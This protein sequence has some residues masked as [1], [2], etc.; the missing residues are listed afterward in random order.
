MYLH[1]YHGRKDPAA[2][3]DDWGEGG[4][5]LEGVVH[6]QWTYGCLYVLF[7]TSEDCEAARRKT[8]WED[9]PHENSLTMN[10]DGDLVE[11]LTDGVTWYFG[12][13]CLRANT[14]GEV[15]NG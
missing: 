13:W 4:P 10:T 6:L 7:A 15:A 2:D 14:P 12:D 5:T 9:G 3:L 1:L 8:G 11:I